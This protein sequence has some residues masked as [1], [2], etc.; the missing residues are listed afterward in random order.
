[1]ASTILWTLKQSL[2]LPLNGERISVRLEQGFPCPASSSCSF[3]ILHWSSTRGSDRVSKVY[4]GKKGELRSLRAS[5]RTLRKDL[6]SKEENQPSSRPSGSGVTAIVPAT[7][8]PTSLPY[9]PSVST[10]PAC[11]SH[12]SFL[13][14]SYSF[15]FNSGFRGGFL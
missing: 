15:R 14:S 9:I 5:Q 2:N 10:C 1:M 7:S 12:C 4:P 11:L 3:R 6:C 8:V 13:P